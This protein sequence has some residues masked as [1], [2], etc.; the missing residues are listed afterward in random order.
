MLKR[1][2][3]E[4]IYAIIRHSLYKIVRNP[5]VSGQIRGAI[6]FWGRRRAPEQRQEACRLRDGDERSGSR[7]ATAAHEEAGPQDPRTGHA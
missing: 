5:S 3:W 4:F 6:N 7:Q 2:A 1:I